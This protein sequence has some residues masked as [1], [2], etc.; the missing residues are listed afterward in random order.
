MLE[1]KA[2]Q[3]LDFNLLK[4]FESLYVE[5]N[6]SATAR[7]LFLTPSAVSHAIKRLRDALNDPLFVRQGQTMQPTPAC[8]QIAPQLL[9]TIARLRQILQ[10]C[11]QFDAATT[12]QTFKIAIHEALEPLIIPK[13]VHQIA[14]LVPNAKLISGTLIRDQLSRQLASG[15]IDLAIDVVRAMTKPITHTKLS[16]DEF[17]VLGASNLFK[18]K[19][20]QAEYLSA[21]HLTVSSRAKGKVVEDFSLLQQ[22]INRN[23]RLRCQSYQTAISIIQHMPLLLTL[24]KLIARRYLVPGVSLYTLPFAIPCSETHLYWHEHT[25]QDEAM[26]WLRQQIKLVLT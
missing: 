16:S 26:S 8:Q 2:I 10:Q 21:E 15:E 13:L 9:E 19:L 20:T 17:C 22:G 6:M 14:P 23:I 11:G 5:R 12:E 18:D 7:A 4:V 3:Q 1:S 25:E 24:P